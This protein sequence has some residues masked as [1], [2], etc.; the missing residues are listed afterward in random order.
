MA[1]TV[2]E[3][4]M[5]TQMG[6]SEK[7]ARDALWVFDSV[8][9]AL[10]V[11]L[12]A[13]PD[14]FSS[15]QTAMAERD[16][17]DTV[18]QRQPGVD[19]DLLLGEGPTVPCSPSVEVCSMRFVRH[20]TI[21]DG[22]EF[23]PNS[24]FSKTW[25]LHN[26]GAVSWG[27]ASLV[28]HD[29]G[30]VVPIPDVAQHQRG[31]AARAQA[32]SQTWHFRVYDEDGEEFG[33]ILQCQIR[34]PHP[35]SAEFI[36]DVSVVD[37]SVIAP[38]HKFRKTW[39]VR[40]NGTVSWPWGARLV[41]KSDNSFFGPI[42]QPLPELAPGDLVHIN[43]ELTAPH[44]FGRCV[45]EWWLEDAEGKPF[46]NHHRVWVSVVVEATGPACAFLAA[47]TV[48]D[49]STQG[50]TAG[51]TSGECLLPA[52]PAEA[53][54]LLAAPLEA[55][56][57]PEPTRPPATD[58]PT[59]ISPGCAA[60]NTDALA[61]VPPST[62]ISMGC[63]ASNT[64]SSAIVTPHDLPP[65]EV[66]APQPK[67]P[68]EE[69]T[70]PH[71]ESTP[72]EPHLESTPVEPLVPAEEEKIQSATTATTDSDADVFGE[73]PTRPASATSPRQKKDIVLASEVS[74]HLEVPPVIEERV[75]CSICNR[76]FN[77]SRIERHAIACEKRQAAAKRPKFD[78]KAQRTQPR[79][80]TPLSLKPLAAPAPLP[81]TVA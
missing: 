59:D 77:S 51:C 44:T 33:Q 19:L 58:G 21:P 30:E 8:E 43:L 23:E 10:S 31:A 66:A 1:E 17:V 20:V 2:S 41:L 34:V 73:A 45:S 54:A 9:G 22:T 14:E 74:K 81:G 32:G 7:Q 80:L 27:N 65:A 49:H 76:K 4:E 47:A 69:T 57:V 64:N 55:P 52:A 25:L 40:N 70:G 36:R 16:R 56:L 12:G 37:G 38:G 42:T 61:V 72:V 39:E 60:S 15:V 35:A 78:S 79:R 62:D 24:V 18:L 6:F 68:A 75:A 26:D 71:V 63:G 11:L 28:N 50:V 48:P 46:V 67:P 13:S 53:E 5:I 3:I 29:T